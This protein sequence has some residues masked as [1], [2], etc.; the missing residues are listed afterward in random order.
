MAGILGNIIGLVQR[1]KGGVQGTRQGLTNY[2]IQKAKENAVR[3]KILRQGFA[4]R[5]VNL[6][7]KSY[8]D[9]AKELEAAG[10]KRV[11]GTHKSYRRTLVGSERAKALRGS[12][13]GEPAVKKSVTMSNKPVTPKEPAPMAPAG[14]PGT[15]AKPAGPA[16]GKKGPGAPKPP[17]K[18]APAGPETPKKP[19]KESKEPSF[20]DM[21]EEDFLKLWK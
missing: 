8:E 18:M 15:P 16:G 11:P 7:N 10:Y 17:K 14:S 5:D 1:M 13:T 19:K 9:F 21:T 6:G 12:V 2:E 3:N 4:P 20:D